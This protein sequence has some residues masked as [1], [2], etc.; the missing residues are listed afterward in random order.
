MFG[1]FKKRCTKVNHN[2]LNMAIVDAT[3]QTLRF[4]Y[5]LDSEMK[6]DVTT[7]S[8]LVA[9]KLRNRFPDK[10]IL[11]SILG[12]VIQKNQ[13]PADHPFIHLLYNAVALGLSCKAEVE[14]EALK[15][16]ADNLHML[17]A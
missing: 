17:T 3:D 16:Y 5:S 8:F 2:E 9:W 1:F 14:L 4:F 6:P 7:V 10:E 15:S 11:K 12:I 13:I